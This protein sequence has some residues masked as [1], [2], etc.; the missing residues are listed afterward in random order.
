MSLGKLLCRDVVI[1]F[2]PRF[3][4]KNFDLVILENYIAQYASFRGYKM[5]CL[6]KGPL[7][8]HMKITD[9]RS[10]ASLVFKGKH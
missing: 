1:I 5:K 3:N 4:S 8:P 7:I 2:L 6:N 9:P 10:K